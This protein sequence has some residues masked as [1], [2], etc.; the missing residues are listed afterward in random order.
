MQGM[1]VASQTR[2]TVIRRQ[3]RGGGT[4]HFKICK[5]SRSSRKRPP[6]KF[7]QVVVTRASRLQECD[8]RQRPNG[9]TIKGGR[10]RE[11]QKLI[12]NDS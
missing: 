12:I 9:K 1:Y 4:Q 10:L 3:G 11:A 8:S 2:A 7:E 5:Y 6:R